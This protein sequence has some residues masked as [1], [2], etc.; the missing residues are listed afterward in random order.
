[1]RILLLLTAA[2][3]STTLFAQQEKHDYQPVD[4]QFVLSKIAKTRPGT[5]SLTKDSDV[6][7]FGITDQEFFTNFGNDRV[8]KIGSE[9]NI[10]NAD[11]IGLNYVAIHALINRNFTLQKQVE[12]AEQYIQ[13]LESEIQELRDSQST[14]ME[15]LEKVN[16]V[17]ELTQI[18]KELEI[19]TTQL[20]EE[21]D[22][23]RE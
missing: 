17:D 11:K 2:L 14:F 5:W 3:L 8:G 18:T 13:T 19:R 21:V 22:R 20:E 6:R 7:H 12:D 1:M 10:P 4:P 23:L 16:Q 9:T 15:M